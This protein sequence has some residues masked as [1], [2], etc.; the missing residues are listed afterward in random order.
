MASVNKMP[1]SC[2]MFCVVVAAEE[3]RLCAPAISQRRRRSSLV[4]LRALA[5]LGVA[6]SK[7]QELKC[8]AMSVALSLKMLNLLNAYVDERSEICL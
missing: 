7:A 8:V 2:K 4:T 1:P 3:E 5:M 6:L